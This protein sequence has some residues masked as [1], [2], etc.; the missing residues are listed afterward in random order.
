MSDYDNEC[1]IVNLKIDDIGPWKWVKQDNGLWNII[2]YEWQHLKQM[3]GKH[4]KRYDVC[5]QAGGAC[6]M[7]PRLLSYT[8]K[9]V[10]T[11]EPNPLSFHCLV[12]NCQTSNV[13]K[14]NM[15][16]GAEPGTARL[17]TNGLS[18]PGEARINAAGDTT[19]NITTIDSLGLDC[20]DFIQLDVETYELE[21]L[22]GAKETIK[23]YKPVISVENGNDEILAFLNTLAPY[24]HV[25]QFRIGS[26]RSDD[27]YKV[28]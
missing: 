5:V 23:K 15:G 19:I 7:Y 28:I 8:F 2:S 1:G 20:C 21:A 4:V 9:R 14:T 22:K 18:N 6:G 16:L 13:I 25:D 24:K 12:N 27:V 11:F 26:D 10:Y 17:K 3:W